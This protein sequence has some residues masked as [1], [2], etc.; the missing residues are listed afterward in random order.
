MKV[1]IDAVNEF[2]GDDRYL[3]DLGIMY[4]DSKFYAPC[5]L[6]II[7]QWSFINEFKVC[8]CEFYRLTCSVME[9]P[10]ER[11]ICNFIDDVPAPPAGKIDINFYINEKM[12]S[13]K[14][15]PINQPTTWSSLPIEPLFECL[16]PENIISLFQMVLLERQ[17][18]FVSSQFSLLTSASETITSL[19]Y[20]FS[21]S[22]VYIPLLPLPLI[23]I[24]CFTPSYQS[25]LIGL[26]HKTFNV[27]TFLFFDIFASIIL[28]LFLYY[29]CFNLLSWTWKRYTGCPD[30]VYSRYSFFILNPR[31]LLYI[32]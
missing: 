13:F 14:C 2:Y 15:P 29:T 6:C 20:P 21:W 28:S 12:V 9:V 31:R 16:S 7:S 1:I 3:L 30:S 17:I 23:G 27:N 22:H 32:R 8:L 10:I 19:L 5:T 25:P 18:V 26:M 11:I 4:S 24:R